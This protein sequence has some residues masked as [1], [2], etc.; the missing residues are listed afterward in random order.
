MCKHLIVCYWEF[1]LAPLY[2]L[3]VGIVQIVNYAFELAFIFVFVFWFN[4][5]FNFILIG[6]KWN[7][8][9]ISILFIFHFHIEM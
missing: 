4:F 5:N 7:C 8:F 3:S 6:R 1:G 2:C 9:H